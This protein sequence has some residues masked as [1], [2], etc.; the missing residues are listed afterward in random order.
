MHAAVYQV[1]QSLCQPLQ[2]RR[3]VLEVGAVAGPDS[4]LQLPALARASHRVGL[5]Q[6]PQGPG[7]LVG[8]A[9]HMDMFADGQFQ[10]VLCNAT[11]E[12]DGQFWLTLQQIRRVTEPGGYIVVGVPGYGPMGTPGHFPAL[13]GWL[14][15][16]LQ[17]LPWPALHAS[18]PTLGVHNFPGDYY[19]FSQQA[20]H[21]IFLAGLVHTRV[22]RVLNPPRFIG[23]GQK[24]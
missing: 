17:A 2:L 1:F 19:R 8:N 9:N 23:I 5:N 24:P 16:L 13:P 18:T 14:H 12:H 21:E 10:A 7:I 20:V 11:L 15:R 6:Q 3:Q 22:Q 4:L